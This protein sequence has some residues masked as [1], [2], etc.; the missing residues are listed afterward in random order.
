[1]SLV[2]SAAELTVQKVHHFQ[3]GIHPGGQVAATLILWLACIIMAP[4]QVGV[5]AVSIVDCSN[6][7]MSSG[8]CDG[9]FARSRGIWMALGAFNGLLFLI[10][11]ILFIFACIDTSRRNRSK[12]TVMVVNP[13]Q[14]W[15]QPQQGWQALPQWQQP[16]PQQQQ[17]QQ[18]QQPQQQQP[19]IP[20]QNQAPAARA[21]EG[22]NEKR[23]EGSPAHGIQEY[24][25]GGT[26]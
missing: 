7:D 19:G 17:Y 11:F 23:P 12:R 25:G 4:L 24:Y 13:G 8:G 2:W 18:S 6:S 3:R 9:E 21:A 14:Y 26:S 10:Y 16:Q 15:P 20:L 5:A 22:S 1:M